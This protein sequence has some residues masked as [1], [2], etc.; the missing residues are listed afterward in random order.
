MAAF[1]ALGLAFAVYTE[2]VGIGA[3]AGFDLMVAHGFEALW[4]DQLRTPALGIAM[5]GGVELSVVLAVGLALYLRY[6]GFQNEAWALLALPLAE[7]AELAYKWLIH[8][9]GPAAFSHG[10]GPSFTMLFEHGGSINSYPSGHILRTV[11][12][13]GLLAFVTYRLAPPGWRQRVAAPLAAVIIAV[14]AFDRLYLGVHWQSDVVGGLL[15]GGV[16]LAGAIAWL[17]RPRGA[18]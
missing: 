14:V 13:F 2:L 8:H 18:A 10:D 6:R 5:L 17:D 7:V 3:L 15:L 4:R 9:P 16:A 12:V 1:A 11:L